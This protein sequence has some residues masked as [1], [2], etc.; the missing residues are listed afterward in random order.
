MDLDM[1]ESRAEAALS[2]LFSEDGGRIFASDSPNFASATFGRD[3]CEVVRHLAN[4]PKYHATACRLLISLAKHQGVVINTTSDE[5]PGGIP[6]EIRSLV[7]DGKEITGRIKE[8]FLMLRPRWSDDPNA[9]TIVYY[10]ELEGSARFVRACAALS[11]GGVNLSE[12]TFVHSSGE[13]RTLLDACR[14]VMGYIRDRRRESDLDLVELQPPVNEETLT[15]QTLKDSRP[16][17]LHVVDGR[18]VMPNR[19]GPRAYLEAQFQSYEALADFA[20]LVGEAEPEEAAR[21]RAEAESLRAATLKYFTVKPRTPGFDWPYE[22]LAAMLDRDPATGEVRRVN[23]LMNDALEGLRGR[24]FGPGGS[25]EPEGADTANLREAVIRMGF[26]HEFL[27]DCGIRCRGLSDGNLF[28]FAEY[29]GALPNWGI[30]I[31]TF[32]TGLYEQGARRLAGEI[33]ARMLGGLTVTED[34]R[35]FIYCDD[36]GRLLFEADENHPATVVLRAEENP[37]KN[38]AWTISAVLEAI[39]YLRQADIEKSTTDRREL[40]DEVL[41]S[42]TQYRNRLDGLLGVL[43]DEVVYYQFEREE[44][45]SGPHEIDLATVGLG[46]SPVRPVSGKLPVGQNFGVLANTWTENGQDAAEYTRKLRDEMQPKK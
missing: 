13:T 32:A 31:H 21:C 36:R 2:K 43:R 35:E 38:Q 12:Q 33:W 45:L 41:G 42:I 26:S 37:Q 1:L 7:V 27:D 17:Y 22:Y 9:D 11:L 39:S 40:E 16:A 46:A 6:H 28:D 29:H 30:N 3:T 4:R 14:G 23:L 34:F 18:P 20:D 10:G 24:F 15:N 5:R 25:G 44:Q 8:L 19:R